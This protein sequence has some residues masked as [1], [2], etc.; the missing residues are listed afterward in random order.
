MQTKITTAR[1]TYQRIQGNQFEYAFNC[2]DGD[3]SRLGSPWPTA[4]LVNAKLLLF[5]IM[6][7]FIVKALKSNRITENCFMD[8]AINSK[9]WYWFWFGSKGWPKVSLL[10]AHYSLTRT[11]NLIIWFGQKCWKHFQLS[12]QNAENKRATKKKE[13]CRFKHSNGRPIAHLT[14]LKH[15]IRWAKRHGIDRCQSKMEPREFPLVSH[16]LQFMILDWI[17]LCGVAQSTARSPLI[18]IQLPLP[19]YSM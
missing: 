4:L 6:I 10:T 5:I 8:R 16:V 13:R 17:G 18:D 7:L 14:T 12:K 19:R 1:K 3:L 15:F 9:R 11:F 2:S